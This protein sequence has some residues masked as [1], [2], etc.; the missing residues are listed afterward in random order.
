MSAGDAR[1]CRIQGC[2]KTHDRKLFCCPGHWW[3]L[4]RPM[5][6]AI[7]SAQRHGVV[8]EEYEQAAADAEAY[9]EGLATSEALR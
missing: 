3:L 2:G 1:M 5:R 9:L 6:D 4:P 8:S 7:Y